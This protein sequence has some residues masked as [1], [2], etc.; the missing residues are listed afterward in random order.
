MLKRKSKKLQS[1]VDMLTNRILTHSKRREI[2]I[3]SY[4]ERHVFTSVERVE[5]DKEVLYDTSRLQPSRRIS[6]FEKQK[7]MEHINFAKKALT[8][9]MKARDGQ[10]E[11][12]N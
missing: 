6:T 4:D 10:T 11:K 2:K 12:R 5:V 1:Q 8:T 9:E 7:I 3:P